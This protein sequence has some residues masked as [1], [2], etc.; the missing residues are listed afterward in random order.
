MPIGGPVIAATLQTFLAAATPKRRRFKD[1]VCWCV[2]R[3]CDAREMVGVVLILRVGFGFLPEVRQ[4]F[5]CLHTERELL[6]V[7]MI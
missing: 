3:Y 1:G 7:F 6:A 2:S 4:Q 5:R